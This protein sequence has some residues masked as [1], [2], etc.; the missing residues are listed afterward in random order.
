MASALPAAGIFGRAQDFLRLFEC[1]IQRSDVVVDIAQKLIP[2]VEG[3][4]PVPKVRLQPGE[5]GAHFLA[6]SKLSFK[7]I[8]NA[9]PKSEVFSPINRYCNPPTRICAGA[10]R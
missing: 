5:L 10:I 4:H 8:V 2:S 7:L 1:L 9:T 6:P 3:R